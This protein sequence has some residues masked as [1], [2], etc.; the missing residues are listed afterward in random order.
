M[1]FIRGKSYAGNL[2]T[3]CFYLTFLSVFV[4]NF[5]GS[6]KNHSN[7]FR[8][9]IFLCRYGNGIYDDG[10]NEKNSYN[11]KAGMICM[12]IKLGLC[13]CNAEAGQN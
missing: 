4:D 3:P 1:Y 8:F 7:A 2:F 5:A 12:N 10:D 6:L 11:K 13:L 9:H